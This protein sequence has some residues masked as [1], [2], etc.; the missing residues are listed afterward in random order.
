MI[1]LKKLKYNA[2]PTNVF[3]I[4]YKTKLTWRII[5]SLLRLDMTNEPI[6]HSKAT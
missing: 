1:E 2:R 6:E 5:R 3:R 4:Q